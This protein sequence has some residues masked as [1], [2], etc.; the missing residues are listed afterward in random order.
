[1][2]SIL[3]AAI[4]IFSGLNLHAQT[5]PIV[6]QQPVDEAARIRLQAFNQVWN[7][8]NEKHYD[9]TFG[10]VDWVKVRETYLPKAVAAKTGD[11]LMLVLRK[12]LGELK[13]SHFGVFPSD[14]AARAIGAAGIGVELKMIGNEPVI[15]RVEPG[16]TGAEAGLGSGFAVTKINGTSV[17]ELLKPLEASMAERQ[18]SESLR[19]LYRERTLEALL[20]GDPGTEAVIEAGSKTFRASRKP[21]TGE[22]SQPVGNFPG[23]Q[24]IFESRRLEGN[25]GYIRFNLWVIPQMAKLRAAVKEFADAKGIIF[26]LR[27][28]PGGVGGM[29]AGLAGVLVNKQS[30][31]GSMRSRG[32][33]LNFVVYPQPDPFLGKVVILTDYGTG[34]TSEVFAAGMQ[35]SGRATVVG[36]TSAGAVLPSLFEKLPT[37]AIFQYAISDYR[38]PNNILIE[39]RGVKPDIA[40]PLTREALL[41]GRDDQLEAAIKFISK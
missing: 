23:Q 17:D 8:V 38:S 34:S 20:S 12:M 22:I 3:F 7:T 37:G 39:G 32:G 28:N 15:W 14:L 31:L 10:G 21:F 6:A 24:V 25:I 27:G 26:D 13:L 5:A 18:L 41:A 2:R 35:E 33:T 4:V 36:E 11:E 9:P 16:S 30:S 29:A 1:M 40:V 19:N